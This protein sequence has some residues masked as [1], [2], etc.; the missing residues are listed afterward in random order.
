MNRPSFYKPSAETEKLEQVV[1]AFEEK[2]LSGTPQD[3][4]IR[5]VA[6]DLIAFRAERKPIVRSQ[7][8]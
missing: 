7:Y 6:K 4:E 5:E 2:K 1:K 8:A 3:V